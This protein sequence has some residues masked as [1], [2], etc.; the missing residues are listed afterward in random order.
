MSL[1]TTDTS[2]SPSSPS[3]GP[4]QISTRKKVDLDHKKII[5]QK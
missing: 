3:L 4:E 1:I 2:I 5:D